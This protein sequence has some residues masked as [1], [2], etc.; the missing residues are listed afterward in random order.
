[1]AQAECFLF[2]PGNL[3]LL[4]M[5]VTTQCAFRWSLLFNYP[6][7][8]LQAFGTIPNF[9]STTSLNG[10]SL[11]DV[12]DCPFAGGNTGLFIFSKYPLTNMEQRFISPTRGIAYAQVHPEGHATPTQ[13]FCSHLTVN[14]TF[15]LI[16]EGV[17]QAAFK[18]FQVQKTIDYIRHK[19]DQ[20]P[21]HRVAY[22]ANPQFAIPRPFPPSY[23][24]SNFPEALALFSAFA[25]E[26]KLVD[27]YQLQPDTQM[28]ATMSA[29]NP[30]T[31]NG[32]GF[33]TEGLNISVTHNYIG[34]PCPPD[35][36]Q[37][38]RVF[39][40]MMTVTTIAGS[41]TGFGSDSFGVRSTVCERAGNAQRTNAIAAAA[42]AHDVAIEATQAPPT[43]A[44]SSASVSPAVWAVL[45]V[46][47]VV[48]FASLVLLLRR[49]L[50][51]R[52]ERR[53]EERL[54]TIEIQGEMR[55]TCPTPVT[56][57]ICTKPDTNEV[58]LFRSAGLVPSLSL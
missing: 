38:V 56:P 49:K 47:L 33:L 2:S 25:M 54:T 31:R 27:S 34:S 11:A 29:T 46:L 42:G 39:D 5:S 53:S 45:I 28:L 36:Q 26:K 48:S 22:L 8:R 15:P 44:A 35:R 14:S 32:A 10:A 18:N 30:L 6:D 43:P 24:V 40:K 55:R 41:Y 21:K 19:M 52:A 17:T 13:V 58:E 37:A 7:L 9:A 12:G 50:Q 51:G 57:A 16:P 3:Q 23:L 1:M 20:Y 4:L